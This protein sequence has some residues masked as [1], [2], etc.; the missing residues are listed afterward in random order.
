MVRVLI[1][2]LASSG[3]FAQPAFEV[4]SVKPA[5]L[6]ATRGIDFRISSGGF[7][8]TT[9]VTVV[10]LIDQA[11]SLKHYQLAD[12]PGWLRSDR[13]DI[14]AKAQGDPSRAQ[15]LA[16]LQ[17]LL[18]DRF[19]L[20]VHR[21]DREQSIYALVAAKR[22][23]KLIE[24]KEDDLPPSVRISFTGSPF[25]KKTYVLSGHKAS[26]AML[27]ENLGEAQRPVLDRTGI[28]GVFDFRLEF[29]ADESKPEYGPSLFTAI[30]EQLG[31]KLESAK[32]QVL[33]LVV[34][35]VEK[36]FSN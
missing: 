9:N 29:A 3:A 11:Y 26:L 20:R 1:A 6:A 36:P 34:D 31:L 21:E 2:L 16:M 19:Q 18:A 30:Q 23:P 7:L 12:G 28:P 24:P 4:A 25:E 22:G 17:T 5:D 15:I 14:E 8:H 35:H 10:N 27:A 33:T 13:F 32:G